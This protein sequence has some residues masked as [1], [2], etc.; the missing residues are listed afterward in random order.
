MGIPRM[1]IGDGPPLPTIRSVAV[2][3]RGSL[4]FYESDRLGVFGRQDI[5]RCVAL[6]DSLPLTDVGFPRQ[7]ANPSSRMAA[8][9]HRYTYDDLVSATGLSRATLSSRG[10]PEGGLSG[11]VRMV[12]GAQLRGSDRLTDGEFVAAWRMGAQGTPSL[13]PVDPELELERWENRWPRLDVWACAS[14][15]GG[16]LL[17]GR[18]YCIECS[19]RRGAWGFGSS[20]HL[21]LRIVGGWM[22]YHHLVLPAIEGLDVHHGDGNRWNNRSPNLVHLTPGEHAAAHK[23]LREAEPQPNV[24]AKRFAMGKATCGACEKLVATYLDR[25]GMR[26]IWPHTDNDRQQCARSDEAVM[27]ASEGGQQGVIE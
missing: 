13:A 10:W 21:E 16:I 18:G 22:S 17:G 15:C 7:N 12:A 3:R 27:L 1:S 20:G 19:A 2:H 9:Q 14:G 6:L 8:K 4:F 11:L 5:D 26:C 25:R 23:L 24:E